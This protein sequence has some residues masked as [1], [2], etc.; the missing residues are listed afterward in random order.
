MK[1]LAHRTAL[2]S[3][4]ASGIGKAIAEAFAHQGTALLLLDIQAAELERCVSQLKQFNEKIIGFCCDITKPEQVQEAISLAVEKFGELHI[5]I[6][7]AGI[8]PLHSF[9]EI[10]L[11][12]WNQVLSVNLT[13]AF[14]LSQAALPYLRQAAEKGRIINIGSLAGI[15]GGIAVGAHY[16]A[17]KAGLMVLGKT[18]A[19]LLAQ[20]RVTVNN[21]CPGT[22]DTPLTQTWQPETRQTLLNKIPLGRFCKPEEIAALALFLASDSAA[23]ITGATLNINGGLLMI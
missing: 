23:Y 11:E 10:T 20:Q 17:S 6:N 19:A 2:I 16:A 7:N 14:L 21:I 4:A 3:G 22:T 13:G 5:L 8:C 12:E 1:E 9:E 18:L 15:S